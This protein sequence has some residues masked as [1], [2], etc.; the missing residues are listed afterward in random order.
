MT[1]DQIST[2]KMREEILTDARREGEEIVVRAKQ[3][4]E[5]FLTGAAAEAQR[6]RQERLDGASKEAARQSEL[7]LATVPVETGRMRMARIEE[8]LGS[9]REEASQ[10]LL[11]REGFEYRETVIALASHAI[12][13]M[14]GDAFIVKLSDAELTNPGDGLGGEIERRVG[15]P[16]SITVLHGADITGGGVVVEDADVRQVWDNSLLKRLERL[17]PEM[18]RQIAMQANFVPKAGPGGDA[19]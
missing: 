6:L 9:V 12:S 4:A 19:P 3:D 5:A 7:I 8:M 18:R 11:A 15:R 14:A 1:T 10:R 2:E 17:W 13:R 16:V